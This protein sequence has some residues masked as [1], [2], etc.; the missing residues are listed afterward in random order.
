MKTISI[1]VKGRVQGVFFREST[2]EK[3]E[4]WGITGQVMNLDNG[5]VKLVAT[6]S[7]EQLD[8]LIDWCRLGPPRAQVTGIEVKELPFEEFRRFKVHRF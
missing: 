5:D 1:T 6:G 8:K 7:Q 4:T 3:A 2:R